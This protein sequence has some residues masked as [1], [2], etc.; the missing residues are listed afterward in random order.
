M[1][2]EYSRVSISSIEPHRVCSF[3]QNRARVLEKTV[4]TSRVFEYSSTRPPTSRDWK[5]WSSSSFTV[6]GRFFGKKTFK[7]GTKKSGPVVLLQLWRQWGGFSKSNDSQTHS[8]PRLFS[9]ENKRTSDRIL[10][11]A[12]L[13]K[14]NLRLS[15]FLITLRP[16]AFVFLIGYFNHH[17]AGQARV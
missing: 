1:L 17:L 9:R 2:D 11:G 10:A 3:N 14:S 16:P 8:A 7:I 4:R 5:K 13:E 15:R 12:P 6:V